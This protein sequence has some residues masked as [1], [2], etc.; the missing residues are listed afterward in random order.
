MSIDWYKDDV[1]I[2]N[3]RIVTTY[4]PSQLSGVTELRLSNAERSDCG[5]YRVVLRSIVGYGVFSTD[6]TD[7]ET[8]FQ[9]CVEGERFDVW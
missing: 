6:E 5:V 3:N 2:P 1:P 7:K 4:S 8:S 9:F